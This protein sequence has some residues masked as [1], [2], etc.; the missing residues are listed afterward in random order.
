[1]TGKAHVG[2]L[3]VP[4]LRR[5]CI[6]GRLATVCRNIGEGAGILGHRLLC[7]HTTAVDVACVQPTRVL[8]DQFVFDTAR[9]DDSYNGVAGV[10]HEVL[11]CVDRTK[12]KIDNE[13]M[14]ELSQ[15]ST[16]EWDAYNKAGSSLVCEGDAAAALEILHHHG[17]TEEKLALFNRVAAGARFLDFRTSVECVGLASVPGRL[18]P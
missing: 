3:G 10:V 5:H 12:G 15:L 14:Y 9:H 16:D 4:E 2:V 18:G 1:M 8:L 13:W 7:S 6:V 11:A 17:V